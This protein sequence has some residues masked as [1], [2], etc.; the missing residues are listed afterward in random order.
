MDVGKN[1]TLSNGD[2][3]EKLVQLFVIADGQLKMTRNDA[4]L[5]VVTSG[6]AGQLENFSC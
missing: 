5:F 3:T 4:S 6:I 2:M 1:T